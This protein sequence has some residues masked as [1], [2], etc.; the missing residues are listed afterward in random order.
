MGGAKGAAGAKPPDR[1]LPTSGGLREHSSMP[2]SIWSGTISFGLVSVPVRL[3]P[4]TRKHDVRFHELDRLTGQ[5]V[6][7]ERVRSLELPVE[8]I[9]EPGAAAG[10][11]LPQPPAE[12]TGAGTIPRQPAEPAARPG[13]ENANAPAARSRQAAD[14]ALPTAAPSREVAAAEVVKGFEIQPDRYVTVS[15]AELSAMAPERSRTIDIEQFVERV[16]VDPIYFE[17]SYYAV[18]D[19]DQLRAFALLLEAMERLDRLAIAWIVLRRRRH[20]A[21]LRP[22][23]GLMLL[24]TMRHADEVL[25]AE[26]LQLPRPDDLTR[27][28]RDMAELLLKTLSGPFEPQRYRDEYRQ[29]VMELIQGR[30]ATARPAPAPLIPSSNQVSDLMEALKASVEQARKQRAQATATGKPPARR[31]RKTA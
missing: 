6:R 2:Q 5:R 14:E 17:T 25:P 29:R 15:D 28:E 26:P 21:A 23:G 11:A 31:R 1:G 16:A 8:P 20:L 30:A 24:T 4:A 9:R 3:Y 27:R 10:S 19:R 13:G 7:H 22:Y 12:S 18:P